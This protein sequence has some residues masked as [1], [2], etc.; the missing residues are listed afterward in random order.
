MATTTDEWIYA[1]EYPWL[2]YAKIVQPETIDGM[3]IA[4]ELL[5]TVLAGIGKTLAACRDALDLVA[6]DT[7]KLP[8]DIRDIVYE[9]SGADR[10]RD[11]LTLL[12]TTVG[13]TLQGTASKERVEYLVG[14]YPTQAAALRLLDDWEA[15][16]VGG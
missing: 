16:N 4:S 15:Q 3:T 2:N 9:L 8:D 7:A 10:L 14:R 12:D 11:L 6:A 5:D 1:P 13:D